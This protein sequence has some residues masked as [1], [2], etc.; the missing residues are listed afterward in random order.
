MTIVPA[1]GRVPLARV[2]TS[3]FAP[4]SAHPPPQK[5]NRRSGR[6]Q[7]FQTLPIFDSP[8]MAAAFLRA[9][10]L[11]LAVSP[12]VALAKALS[13]PLARFAS[14]PSP[15]AVIAGEIHECMSTIGQQACSHLFD[16]HYDCIS[17][18]VAASVSDQSGMEID[19]WHK[20]YSP[21]SDVE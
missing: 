6:D 2:C 16:S 1:Y 19:H 21:R 17:G 20:P 4:R 10:L 7:S 12:S 11:L 14:S 9:F 13:A 15:C 5:P 18:E 3:S 8:L